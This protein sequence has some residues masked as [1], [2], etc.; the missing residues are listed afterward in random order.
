MR[1]LIAVFALL[2]SVTLYGQNN[3][4]MSFDGVDDYVDFGNINNGNINNA[5]FEFWIK[6]IETSGY[7]L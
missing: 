1:Y 3:Y 4:T 7:N 6:T 2:L 5:T